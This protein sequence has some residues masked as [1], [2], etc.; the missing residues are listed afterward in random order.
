MTAKFEKTIQHM[1]EAEQSR[2]FREFVDM[3][4]Q[5]YWAKY[6]LNSARLGWEAYKALHNDAK[7]ATAEFD[8]Y[9]SNA[10]D[11]AMFYRGKN[12]ERKIVVVGLNPS[13]A[14]KEKA[15][16]TL[17]KIAKAASHNGFDGFVVTHLYALRSAEPC[18]LPVR[19]DAKL[20]KQN[21]RAITELILD[22]RASFWAAWG[23]NF[24]VR[25]YLAEALEKI[26]E[27]AEDAEWLHFGPLTKDG[28][29]RH[30][31]RLRYGW[32]FSAFDMDG[33]LAK[34]LP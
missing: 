2:E 12:G 28:H 25:P 7:Q 26:C 15:D 6:D 1:M 8:L 13:T 5:D 22:G 34:H 32:N 16:T 14:M 17:C 20:M 9:K 19:E 3:L 31:S 23:K 30:P 4:P 21:V 33:Y 29:P 18:G 24:G 27:Q 10:D 11:S